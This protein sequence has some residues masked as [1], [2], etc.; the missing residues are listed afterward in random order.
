MFLA[1][2]MGIQINDDRY[3]FLVG[4]KFPIQIGCNVKPCPHCGAAMSFA[5]DHYFCR[6]CGFNQNGNEKGGNNI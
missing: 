2:P 3:V 4:A 6:K 5:H 1:C